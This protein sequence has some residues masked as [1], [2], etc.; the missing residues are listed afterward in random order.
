M[1]GHLW[2]TK[3]SDSV[4]L[5]PKHVIDPAGVHGNSFLSRNDRGWAGEQEEAPH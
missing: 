5:L 3:N 4:E 1:K 2:C